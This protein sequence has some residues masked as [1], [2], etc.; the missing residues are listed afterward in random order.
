VAGFRETAAGVVV[1]CAI[2]LA[3]PGTAAGALEEEEPICVGD[4]CQPLPP[5]P[6][7]PTPGTLMPTGGNPPLHIDEPHKKKKHK[8]KHHR[9]HGKHGKGGRSR[10]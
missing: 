8:K 2:L 6:E 5:E 4:S 7:D 1:A 3:G 10:R 9:H